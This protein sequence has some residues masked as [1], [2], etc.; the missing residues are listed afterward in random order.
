MFLLIRLNR[1]DPDY[2]LLEYLTLM[3]FYHDPV[4]SSDYNDSYLCII[5]RLHSP[6]SLCLVHARNL[7]VPLSEWR[8]W[9][10]VDKS[11]FDPVTCGL[12]NRHTKVKLLCEG[13]S[14]IRV[15]H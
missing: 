3:L 9:E 14:A 11:F 13:F 1:Y 8:Y 15:T 2:Q 10:G 7:V 6:Y 4:P 12:V 5:T